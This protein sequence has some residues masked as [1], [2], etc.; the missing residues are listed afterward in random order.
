MSLADRFHTAELLFHTGTLLVTLFLGWRWLRRAASPP[1]RAAWTMALVCDAGWFGLAILLL[2][3]GV[4]AQLNLVVSFAIPRSG[5]PSSGN[6]HKS[7]CALPSSAAST[8]DFP[9][10]AKQRS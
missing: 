6:F 2:A 8:S 10:S 4:C 9:P 7:S 3:L 1:R 5:S